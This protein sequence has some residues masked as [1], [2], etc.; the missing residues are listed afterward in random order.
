MRKTREMVLRNNAKGNE[1]GRYYFM[2]R[3]GLRSVYFNM[4]ELIG[5]YLEEFII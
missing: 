1:A 3:F 4:N 2:E 5:L